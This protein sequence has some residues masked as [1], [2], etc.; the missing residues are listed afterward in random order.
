M[1][2]TVLSYGLP[3]IL[4]NIPAHLEIESA[5]LYYVQLSNVDMLAQ[6]LKEILNMEFDDGYRN[7]IRSMLRD[8]CNWNRIAKMTLN[9]YQLVYSGVS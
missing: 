7:N 5:G 4:S 9:V 2:P 8:R 6:K 3:V 1:R